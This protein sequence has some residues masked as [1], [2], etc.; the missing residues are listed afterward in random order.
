MGFIK[1]NIGGKIF[2]T[3]K[4]IFDNIPYLNNQSYPIDRSPEYFDLIL[5]Y[6]RTKKIHH[7]YKKYMNTIICKNEKH[8]IDY[9]IIYDSREICTKPEKIIDIIDEIIFYSIKNIKQLFYPR[10]FI[11]NVMLAY[12]KCYY[13]DSYLGRMIKYEISHYDDTSKYL[14]KHEEYIKK[15]KLYNDKYCKTDDIQYDISSDDKHIVT[16]IVLEL[17]LLQTQI[18]YKIGDI[19]Q[20]QYPLYNY[21]NIDNDIIMKLE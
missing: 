14:D 7:S 3:N 17:N 9:D 16:S 12:P 6:V 10:I 19:L 21:T 1:I 13:Y 8:L 15:Y 4:T 18:M 2:N 20:K 5:H 11:V